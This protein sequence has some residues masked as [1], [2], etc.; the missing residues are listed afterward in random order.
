MD[1]SDPVLEPEQ[2]ELLKD[3]ATAARGVERDARQKFMFVQTLGGSELVHPGLLGGHR[4]DV[5]VGDLE[6]LADAG[7]LNLSRTDRGTMMF[8]VSPTGFRYV[9]E[10]T[11]G[12]EDTNVPGPSSVETQVAKATDAKAVFVVHGRN[13]KARTAMFAFL[14]SLGLAPLEW[15]QARKLT[16][17][18]TPYVGDIL[19]AAF[20]RASAVVVLLTPDDE[21]RLKTQFV[22]A[23]DPAYESEL[24]GQARANVLFEAGMAMG[25]DDSRTILVELGRV[26]AFS[27]V[28]GRHVLRFA[29][30]VASRQELAERLRS[31]GC[32]VD[33][34]GI[35]WHTE[36]AFPKFAVVRRVSL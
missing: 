28:G 19:D 7:L 30:N 17:T 20:A 24:T 4:S 36:G 27:D 31:A 11:S 34:T 8:D 25:R 10:L 14:R 1:R 22:T 18:P 26:K 12:A 29:D 33:T 9:L 6:T 23:D 5:Y 3:L 13:T 21:A 35:D 16:G 2:I 32:D 15:S